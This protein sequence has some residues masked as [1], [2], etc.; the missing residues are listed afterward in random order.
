MLRAKRFSWQLT[1]PRSTPGA[2][3]GIELVARNGG[4]HILVKQTRAKALAS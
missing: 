1:V 3:G 4:N 2:I